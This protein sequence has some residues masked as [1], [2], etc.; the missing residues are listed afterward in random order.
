MSTPDLPP[1][2]NN[3]AGESSPYLRQH[4][5][6]PVHW[7]PWCDSALAAARADD[8]PILLS[9][10]YSSC[11]WCHVMAHESF[12]DPQVAAVMNEHFVNIKV[13]REERPDLDKIY[14]LS[15]QL[16]TRSSG[17]W[18]LTMFLDPHNLVPFFGGTYF[19]KEPRYH[20]PGFV[21]LML[22][23]ARVYDEQRDAL[24]EQ[25]GQLQQLFDQITQIEG[26]PAE[27]RDADLLSTCLTATM[28]QYDA[29][30]G[31]FSTAPK[32]P[33]PATLQ[34]LLE[35]WAWASHLGQ[36]DR[37]SLERLMFT[38]TK[39]A[40]G[41]IFDHVGG[42]FYRYATDKRWMIPHF[43]KMLN[44]N[45][46]LLSLYSE[47]LAIGPDP[48]FTSTVEGIADWLLRDMQ[49]PDGGFYA[50]LDAD[51]E[52]EEG[53]Y[54]LWHRHELKRLLSDD[55]YLVVETLY[56]VDKPANF[57]NRWHLHRHDAWH[58]VIERLSLEREEADALL[59]SARDKMLTAR[60]SRVAPARDDKILTAWNAL[61]IKGL[62]EAGQRLARPEW[63]GAAEAALGFLRAELIQ[64]DMLLA[65]WCNGT[66]RYRAYLDDHAQL[67]DALL[68]L[69]SIRWSD[70]DL[71]L[72]NWLA[73]VLLEDFQDP[74][75]GGFYFTAGEQDDLIMR[76]KP[77]MDD[78]MAPG[79]AV[80]CRALFRL[81]HLTGRQDCLAAVDST[82][83]WARPQIEHYP[84]AHCAMLS[85]LELQ[86]HAPSL[87]IIRYPE[88]RAD[89]ARQ[90]LGV[91]QQGLRPWLHSYAIPYESSA[92][93]AYLPRMVSA[94]QRGRVQAYLCQDLSCSLPITDLASLRDQLD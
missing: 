69:L 42:G 18:P 83:D 81:G 71:A 94:E 40:R 70:D 65:S 63:I 92:I 27:M 84:A 31:G 26:G 67:L 44:D 74:G 33:M 37:E 49:Q 35:H 76:P 17:G 85:A 34:F 79:N 62:A 61:A 45:G 36:R 53:R 46:A 89:E 1:G 55:E 13:D 41:G 54:Y 22:R 80:A 57:G 72:A 64:G 60:Q 9:I 8:K 82:L 24:S 25:A 51:S 21:D 50:A 20:L 87:V 23:V 66:A 30:E 75:Q 3:L 68:S 38:L 14:Q 19:P 6:N 86:L 5:D 58:A 11:H 93:P 39:M 29:A 32:F 48:L 52:G 2:R 77:T 43:E 47:A 90:W 59:Q 88:S 56:G 12:A 78:A 15:H 10:G 7:Q 16:L 4:A 28:D 91:C 73:D